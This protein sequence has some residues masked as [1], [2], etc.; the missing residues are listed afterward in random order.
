MPDGL[1]ELQV[2]V[3]AAGSEAL[4]LQGTQPAVTPPSHSRHGEEPGWGTGT[5]GS[6]P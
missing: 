3:D 1:E 2:L 4:D 6:D 5:A